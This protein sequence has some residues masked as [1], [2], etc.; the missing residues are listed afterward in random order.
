[1]FHAN[2]RHSGV[3]ISNAAVAEM[4]RLHATGD[5]SIRELAREFEI[6]KSQA[7]RILLNEQR[8]LTPADIIADYDET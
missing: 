7:G 1:M 2:E 8:A 6:G 5:F 4:R 3:K